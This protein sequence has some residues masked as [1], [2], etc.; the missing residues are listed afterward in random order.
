LELEVLKVLWRSGPASIRQVR[1]ELTPTRPLAYTSVQTI[2]NIMVDKAYLRRDK[3]LGSYVYRSR[4]GE[5]TTR[6][7][8]LRDLVNRV[9]DG[10]A[11]AAALHL[12]EAAEIVP[13]ELAQLRALLDRK[14]QE[15]NP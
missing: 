13:D 15:R 1:E 14:A 2:M 10:S 12:L 5:H 11:G 7:R 3:R 6:R 8:M 9:F 4:I